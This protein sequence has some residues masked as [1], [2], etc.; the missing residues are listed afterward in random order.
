MRQAEAHNPLSGIILMVSAML[1]LP[2]LDACAKWLGAG[3]PASQVSAARFTMQML[4]LL[5]LLY[6]WRLTPQRSSF[7][8]AQI[9][10][11]VCLALA[12]WLFFISLKTL[13]MAEAI[14]IFF[15]EPM[16]LTIF[17]ALFL[18]EV[19]RI[20]RIIAVL[21][22]FV[23]ALIVIQPS[24]ALFG[25]PALLPLGT[26][27]VFAL[28]MIVTRKVAQN[29]HPIEAQFAMSFYAVATIFVLS[30][31]NHLTGLESAGWRWPNMTELGVIILL[32]VIATTGHVMIV[33]ALQKADAGLLAPFQYMEILGATLLGYLIFGDIPKDTTIIGASIII[34]SGLYLI[35]RERRAGAASATSNL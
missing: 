13:P 27:I 20:R 24:F 29:T 9:I 25:W 28:Y 6:I 35:H 30:G 17:G 7:S 33:F 31:L 16:I 26:A 15:V 8:V 3:L 34:G 21:F 2:G 5:P 22:G 11:G 18:G 19:I 1:L 4:L 12:T 14:A 23:G 32:G 10:R